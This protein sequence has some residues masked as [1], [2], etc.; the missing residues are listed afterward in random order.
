MVRI[1]DRLSRAQARP[2]AVLI[3]CALACSTIAIVSGMLGTLTYLEGFKSVAGLNLQHLRPL[4]TIFSVAWIYLAGVAV[5]YF[6]LI[7]QSAQLT[8]GFW[9][10]LKCQLVLWGLAGAGTLVTVCAGVF[11]GREY[12]GGHWVWSVLIYLG[13]ILF[14]WNFFSVVGLSLKGKPAFVYMWYTSLLFFLWTFAEGHA[15]HLALVGDYPVRDLAIQWK[16]YGTMAGSFN[17]LVY[18]SLGYLGCCL[19][20]DSRYG[21]SN[22][23]F[24]LFFVGVLNSFT[25]F[26]HHTYHIPQSHLVKWISYVISMTE[27]I[28]VVK[29]LLSLG[30]LLRARTA[31]SQNPGVSF[32]V[33][34]ATVWSFL[35]VGIAVVIAVPPVNTLI[36]GTHFVVAHAMGSMLGI[37]C[38]LLW[39]ALLYIIQRMVPSQR[40]LLT[41]GSVVPVF[42]LVSLGIFLLVLL[43]SVKGLLTGYLRYMG[44]VAPA[45]PGFLT[46]F[47]QLFVILGALLGVAILYV[48]GAWALSVSPFARK[49]RLAQ[50]V[51]SRASR[52]PESLS[53]ERAPQ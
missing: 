36:H 52:E 17:L 18:G 42:S 38:M 8:R 40:R 22:T 53:D 12:I 50:S 44:P 49:A 29:Y 45:P 51:L 1:L 35:L 19:S 34:M 28:I 6:Y 37:D 31:R 5:V 46:W 20:K 39:A 14:A 3:L 41:S 23:A 13:W 11:S 30:A 7:S 27:L 2:L 47:P 33:G 9:L 15:W 25:N 32:I 4:H 26:G 48:N 43:L 24:F 16:S 10:R 21:Y